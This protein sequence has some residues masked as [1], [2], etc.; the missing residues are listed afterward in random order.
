MN[1]IYKIFQD[2]DSDSGISSVL[3][4]RDKVATSI[5]STN[6]ATDDEEELLPRGNSLNNQ[7]DEENRRESNASSIT[8]FTITKTSI[9]FQSSSTTASSYSSG[10]NMPNASLSMLAISSK[11]S[12][13][14]TNN[15]DGKSKHGVRNFF[16]KIFRS[17]S[18]SSHNQATAT[19]E[20]LNID[21]IHGTAYPSMSPLPVT[22]GPIRLFVIRHGERLD[23]YYS[24]QWLQQA[25]DKDGNFCRFSPILP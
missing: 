16:K 24:S 11:Q 20:P 4:P 13:V 2:I 3:R 12:L 17:S 7:T 9:E 18:N 5:S 8:N 19:V 15:I 25:F 6:I 14:N 22:Q 21:R 10:I 23:R 1:K